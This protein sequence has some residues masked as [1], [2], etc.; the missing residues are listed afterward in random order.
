MRDHGNLKALGHYQADNLTVLFLRQER[1]DLEEMRIIEAL[2]NATCLLVV[3]SN[4]RRRTG[5]FDGVPFYTAVS[6]DV[7]PHH[8]KQSGMTWLTVYD[9]KTGE[10]LNG[11]K[12]REAKAQAALAVEQLL[13]SELEYEAAE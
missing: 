2:K 9:L 13:S 12:L 4:D 8:V 5:S 7:V 1:Q 3:G 10:P 11:G 6:R